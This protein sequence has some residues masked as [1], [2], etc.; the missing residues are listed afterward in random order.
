MHWKL[1]TPSQGI[2]PPGVDI[3]AHRQGCGVSEIQAI[4]TPA[5]KYQLLL[6]HR[7][8]FDS[9]PNKSCS[10]LKRQYGVAISILIASKGVIRQYNTLSHQLQMQTAVIVADSFECSQ[11]DSPWTCYR[12]I[13]IDMK[14]YPITL[15]DGSLSLNDALSATLLFFV[16]FNVFGRVHNRS[17]KIILCCLVLTRDSGTESELLKFCRFQLRIQQNG[18]TRS[19]PAPVSTPQSCKHAFLPF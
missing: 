6:R 3:M 19:T 17:S 15:S 12:M 4:P 13:T 18:R 14:L 5:W 16:L 10:I 9:Q 8:R 2:S 11:Y 1:F 7:L